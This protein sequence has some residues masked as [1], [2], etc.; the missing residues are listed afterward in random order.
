MVASVPLLT[1][2]T[3]CVPVS[4]VTSSASATSR[5]PGAPKLV[6]CVAASTM[7]SRTPA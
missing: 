5:Q 7:A 3:F 1:K 6:P 4:R 2:R